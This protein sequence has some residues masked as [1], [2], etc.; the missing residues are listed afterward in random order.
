MTPPGAVASISPMSH[1]NLQC[2]RCAAVHASSMATLRCGTCGAPLDVLYTEATPSPKDGLHQ[3]R[4]GPPIPLPLHQLD[5][6]VSLGEGDTPCVELPG[7]GRLLGLT[8]LYAKLEFLNPTSSFKD[9][10][11][12]IMMSVAKEQ[13]VAAVV[14]DSSGNA[15]ASVAAYAARS[16]ARAHVFVPATAPRAKIQQIEVYGAE[17]HVVDGPREAATREAMA[18][19][20]ASGLVYASHSL[21]PYFAEGT[22]T[23]AYEI[24]RQMTNHSPD[25]I[26]LPVGNGS[27]FIGAWKG[28]R[29]LQDAGHV[30][31]VPRLHCIQARGVMPIVAA[32]NGEG[33]APAPGAQTVAGGISVAEPPRQQ[34]VL[35]GLAATEGAA[36]AV[37]DEQILKWQRLLA[38]T[39]GI[40]AE[41]TSAAALAG[42]H[43]LV[44]GGQVQPSDCVLVPITGSGLKEVAADSLDRR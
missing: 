16:G 5:S 3:R 21:S 33:W 20:R 4:T 28:F 39:E 32:Y 11:A 41:P 6:R 30:S 38:E 23:F 36:L 44:L 13:G 8:R 7:L 10:G 25:H 9:R 43:R 27:L 40:Y 22:K 15:G 34:Q 24:A 26:V 18:F 37:D 29:E 2:T 35:D 19:S 17:V 12:A 1:V 14:E 42:L 31:D